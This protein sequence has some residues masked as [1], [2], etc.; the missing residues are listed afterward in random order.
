[1]PIIPPIKLCCTD[2]LSYKSNLIVPGNVGSFW[3][4][5]VFQ[6]QGSIH[7]NRDSNWQYTDFS[8]FNLDFSDSSLVLFDST[9]RKIYGRSVINYRDRKSTR[10]NSSHV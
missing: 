4:Y 10:L 6:Y 9:E 7:H 5:N 8:S 1:P 3:K 2:T